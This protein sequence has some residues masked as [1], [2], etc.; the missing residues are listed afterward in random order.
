MG[1]EK[2]LTNKIRNEKEEGEITTNTKKIQES[3][4]TTLKTYIQISWKM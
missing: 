3:S 1:K 2:T 4:R